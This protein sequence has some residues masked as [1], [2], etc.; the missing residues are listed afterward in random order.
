MFDYC[1]KDS[2]FAFIIDTKYDKNADLAE[3]IAE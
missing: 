1:G 2:I 3:L